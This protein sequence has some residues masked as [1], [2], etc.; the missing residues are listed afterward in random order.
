MS[1]CASSSESRVRSAG[2]VIANVRRA[3]RRLA[4]SVPRAALLAALPCVAVPCV[5]VPAARL[6]AQPIQRTPRL[7]AGV[8]HEP[9][10]SEATA[11]RT[12]DLRVP[13]LSTGP[14]GTLSPWYAPLL[15]AAV[16]GAGQ[17]LLRQQR[18][19]AYLVVEGYLVLEAVR[20]RRDANRETEA[21][22]EIARTVARAGFG[23]TAPDGPWP[24]YE[25]LQTVLESGAFNRT[26]GGV[27]TP[28][29]DPSTFNGSIWRLARETFWR[30]PEVAPDPGSAEYQRAIAFYRSRAAGESFL[31]SWRDAQLEQDLY[32]QTIDRSNEAARRARQMVGLIL[33]NH[34]LSLVD[35]YVSVRLRVYGVP[36][37]G[38]AGSGP[39]QFGIAGTVPLPR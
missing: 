38:G 19:V 5:A 22:R 34:A 39:A 29:T 23:G 3:L 15:S 35:A 13:R 6:F 20:S 33:A 7:S 27:F 36:S 28:E 18:A 1:P 25:R 31:W 24:Y 10:P 14:E 26:P 9:L 32:R 30:D 16:P 4:G 17:G 12:R 11:P 37:G 21:Y 2:P 8:R